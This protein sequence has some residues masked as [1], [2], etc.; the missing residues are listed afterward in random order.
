MLFMN[1]LQIYESYLSNPSDGN[2]L[3]YD[4]RQALSN[5]TIELTGRD[6][7]IPIEFAGSLAS[8]VFLVSCFII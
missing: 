1:G 6:K 5:L 2:L 7:F 3:L 8:V 4:F